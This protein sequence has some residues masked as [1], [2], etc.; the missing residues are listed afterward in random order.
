[1]VSDGR[2]PLP[3]V[4]ALGFQLSAQRRRLV[5]ATANAVLYDYFAYRGLAP[6]PWVDTHGCVM[7][8]LR[9]SIWCVALPWVTLRST[10]GCDISP[11]CGS[12][13]PPVTRPDSRLQAVT[14][15]SPCGRIQEAFEFALSFWL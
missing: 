2:G 1:M 5:P 7:P 3:N 9:G 15:V 4:F 11:L 8:P 12:I 6:I 14:N 13:L 10:H